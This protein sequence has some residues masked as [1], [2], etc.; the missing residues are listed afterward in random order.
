[1]ERLKVELMN[2]SKE[3]DEPRKECWKMKHEMEVRIK[4]H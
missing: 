3:V 4:E 1:M 2:K